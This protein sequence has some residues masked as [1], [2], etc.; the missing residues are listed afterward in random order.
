MQNPECLQNFIVINMIWKNGKIAVLRVKSTLG[1]NC[2]IR[3]YDPLQLQNGHLQIAK[4]ENPN[5]FFMNPK[6][7]DPVISAKARQQPLHLQKT[8]LYDL[9]TQAGKEYEIVLNHP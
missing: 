6:T 1:G 7:M 2:R 8:W 5:L 9:Q 4:N 3:S